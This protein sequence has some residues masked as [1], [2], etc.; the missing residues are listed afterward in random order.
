MGI[1]YQ[2]YLEPYRSELLRLGNPNELS[3]P[4]IFTIIS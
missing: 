3:L 4:E 1:I 2:L